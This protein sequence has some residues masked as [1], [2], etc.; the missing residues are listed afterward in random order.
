MKEKNIFYKSMYAGLF[1]TFFIA[2]IVVLLF[3]H[4]G[5]IFLLY[6]ALALYTL[7]FLI[8]IGFEIRVLFVIKEE[9]RKLVLKA[10]GMTD[11]QSKVTMVSAGE[12]EIKRAPQ[13]ESGGIIDEEVDRV[14][15]PKSKNTAN[16]IQ[17]KN[18]EMGWTITKMCFA[19][20]GA[21]FTIV[22]IILL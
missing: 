15:E 13:G 9:K 8:M 14:K 11:A 16:K 18:K 19:A 1:V 3:Q 7:G 4:L 12:R 6:T 17:E 20:L 5:Y 21:I 22:I 2:V 10:N